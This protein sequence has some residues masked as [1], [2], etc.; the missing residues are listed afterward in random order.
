MSSIEKLKEIRE[1]IKQQQEDLKNCEYHLN[2]AI[3]VLEGGSVRVS[4]TEVEID[5]NPTVEGN[6]KVIHPDLPPLTKSIPQ[7]FT[8]EPLNSETAK[9]DHRYKNLT[10]KSAVMNCLSRYGRPMMA[11]EVCKMLLAGGSGIGSTNPLGSTRAKLSVLAKEMDIDVKKIE[12][13][14]KEINHYS[15]KR[16]E[17]T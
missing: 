13:D 5:E 14:G 17:D 7:T 8:T 4:I 1:E 11:T 6:E 15:L 3:S 12:V 10:A 16:V 2:A 9:A